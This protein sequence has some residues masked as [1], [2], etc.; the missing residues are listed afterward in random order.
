ASAGPGETRHDEVNMAFFDYFRRTQKSATL[1]KDGLSSIVAR[2]RARTRG[3]ADY[4]PQL[5]QELLAVRARYGKF[6]LQQVRVWLARRGGCEVLELNMTM[7]KAA[8][9][10]QADKA[11]AAGARRGAGAAP[12]V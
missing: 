5:Q 6:D 12:A 1:A 9:E 8:S 11:L 4:L 2:E 7:P 10:A 3:A